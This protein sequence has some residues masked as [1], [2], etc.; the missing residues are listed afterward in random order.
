MAGYALP[1]GRG[2]GAGMI[3]AVSYTDTLEEAGFAI[4]SVA[5]VL[6]AMSTS[7]ACRDMSMALDLLAKTADGALAAVK[8]H[9]AATCVGN[10][11]V[12]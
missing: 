6:Y 12:A 11:Q 10:R 2:G 1:R 8:A 9:V 7:E 4:E 3:A 5:Q